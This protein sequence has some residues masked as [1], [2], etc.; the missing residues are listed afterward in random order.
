MLV[1][2]FQL[3]TQWAGGGD[4]D[5][6]ADGAAGSA[7]FQEYPKIVKG[8]G[9]DLGFIMSNCVINLQGLI[10]HCG[11]ILQQLGRGQSGRLL[12]NRFY[13][14]NNSSRAEGLKPGTIY[15]QARGG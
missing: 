1:P 14:G 10:N 5:R 7:L 12:S 4:P 13:C 6:T 2:V 9:F 15:P 8:M 11:M 3:L